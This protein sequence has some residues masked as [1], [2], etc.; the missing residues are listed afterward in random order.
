MVSCAQAGP[1]A[2]MTPDGLATV[3]DP[4][5]VYFFRIFLG[6]VQDCEECLLI[7]HDD[8]DDD[9]GR[10]AYFLRPQSSCSLRRGDARSIR[11]GPFQER[12]SVG[13]EL[14]ET[15]K[16]ALLACASEKSESEFVGPH[17]LVVVNG[18]AVAMNFVD[19]E[20][21][22]IGLISFFGAEEV[23]KIADALQ[24]EPVPTVEL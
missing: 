21:V 18:D 4:D 22:K 9:R 1:T 6:S 10:V 13:L 16:R 3:E 24:P 5:A 15:G 17:F 20:M 12:Y 19:A 8:A 7:E 2:W 14:A 11:S 23:T